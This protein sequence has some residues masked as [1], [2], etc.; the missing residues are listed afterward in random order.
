MKTVCGLIV[1]VVSLISCEIAYSQKDI[2]TLTSSDFIKGLDN[3][4][5]LRKKLTENGLT[6]V[7]KEG[8][9]TTKTGS[10]E[11]WKLNSMVFVDL[12]YNS[13][14]ENTIKVGI[15]ETFTG[16]TERLI[17]SFPHKKNGNKEDHQSS[18]NITPI[19]KQINYSLA[20]SRDTDNIVVTIWFDNP[21]YF[22][23]YKHGKLH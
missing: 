6:V 12:I 8:I 21:Y 18:I 22:F 4:D 2:I 10:Y 1:F 13:D 15:H 11:S 17:K 9:D 7:G 3:K 20:Y 16:L 19:N 5:Y 14:R 23:D